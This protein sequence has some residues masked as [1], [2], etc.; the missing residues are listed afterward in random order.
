ML[1]ARQ[2]LQHP[3]FTQKPLPFDV[4]DGRIARAIEDYV[5]LVR[6][7]YYDNYDGLQRL[8]PGFA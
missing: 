8:L 3:R 7:L 1:T 4:G 2:F 5:I 6:G